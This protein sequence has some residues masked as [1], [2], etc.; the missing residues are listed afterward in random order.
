MRE[1]LIIMAKKSVDAAEQ[2]R[3]KLRRLDLRVYWI[4]LHKVNVIKVA[5]SCTCVY[6]VYQV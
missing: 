2:N 5:A 1:L 4:K 6:Q 3:I